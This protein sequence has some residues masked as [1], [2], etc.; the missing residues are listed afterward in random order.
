MS[1]V[2][3]EPQLFAGKPYVI[4]HAPRKI[5]REDQT[6]RVGS[7]FQKL[8]FPFIFQLGF[9]WDCRRLKSFI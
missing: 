7:E 4:R 3:A 8:G 2:L 6:Y 1:I 5:R 9:G